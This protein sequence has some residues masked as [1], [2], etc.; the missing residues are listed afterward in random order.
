[1]SFRFLCVFTLAGANVLLAATLAIAGE[2]EARTSPH[3]TNDADFQNH[4]K[5][6]GK[7][8][9]QLLIAMTLAMAVLTQGKV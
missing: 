3:S 4:F 5:L 8:N 7:M 2:S 9:D 6:E 1:M